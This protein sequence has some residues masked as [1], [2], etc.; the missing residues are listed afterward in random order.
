MEMKKAVVTGIGLISVLG[1]NLTDYWNGLINGKSGISK[2]TLFDAS[3][4]PTQI[5]GEIPDFVAA[6]YIDKKEARRMSRSAQMALSAA[7]LAF[8]DAGL[9]ADDIKDPERAGVVYGSAIGG[10]D[11][12]EEGIYSIREKGFKRTNPFILPSGLP[13]FAAFTIAK[14]YQ[15]LGQNKTIT[16]ACATS[17]QTIGEAMDLIRYG[18]ADIVVAGGSDCLILDY[19][20]GGFCSM[21]AMPTNFND[22]PTKASRPWDKDREGFV[23]SEGAA[24]V[25]L[26]S[27]EHAK[28][29]NA[30]IYAEIA[31]Y[32][33]SSDAFHMAAPE[34]NGAGPIRSMRWALK[35]AGMNPDEIDYVN[36]HGSSTPL[37]DIIETNA[38]KEV[39]GDHAYNMCMTSTKAMIGHAM[40]ATGALEAIASILTIQN[41][42]VPPTINL[43][44]ADE[45]CDLNYVPNTAQE[46]PI[47]AAISN[48]FG[49]GGQNA[50][51]VIRKY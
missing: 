18:K 31:G 40:G 29:R 37:N 48:S 50:T 3:P 11:R 13:N 42:I 19:V 9:T 12:V 15:L 27:E 34:P 32:S 35:D 43:D 7:K 14:Q 36:A 23:L 28:A 41:D 33:S 2:I 47:N 21:R 51:M 16:T 46:R 20:V 44:E 39:F 1:D 26:E 10:V 17:T 45:G 4:F 6:N 24:I 8:E 30:K 49:L 25:I 38:V 22:E 5:G